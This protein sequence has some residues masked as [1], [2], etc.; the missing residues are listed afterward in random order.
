MKKCSPSLRLTQGQV[1]F[2]DTRPVT[3]L[4]TTKTGHDHHHHDPW[5]E[6]SEVSN[7]HVHHRLFP[8]VLFSSYA[9]LVCTNPQLSSIH[10]LLDL[11]CRPFLS[12]NSIIEFFIF[13]LSSILHNIYAP[14]DSISFSL[15]CVLDI[16]LHSVFFA[17]SKCPIQV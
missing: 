13:L 5:A 8:V 16:A 14:T 12:I 11:H 1:V 3:S 9:D 2:S 6:G 4:P 10:S 15:L 7:A 17:P